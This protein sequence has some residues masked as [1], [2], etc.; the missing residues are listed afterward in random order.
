M[1]PTVKFTIVGRYEAEPDNYPAGSTPQQMADLDSDEVASG[2]VSIADVIEWAEG[3]D[4][5]VRFEAE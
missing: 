4:L 3:R 2:G 1:S 5:E